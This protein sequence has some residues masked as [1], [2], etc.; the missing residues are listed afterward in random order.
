MNTDYEY[1]NEDRIDPDLICSI[2]F[3]P[4]KDPVT[5]PCGDAFCRT[6]ITRWI[7]KQDASCPLC[8]KSLSNR[9]LTPAIHMVRNILDRLQVTC[10]ACGQSNLLRGQFQMHVKNVCPMTM[11][12][13]PGTDVM[14]LW[15]GR[16]E[17][18][19]QHLLQS[20]IHSNTIEIDPFP[21]EDQKVTNIDRV[22]VNLRGIFPISS[23]HSFLGD[24]FGND[25]F[26][27]CLLGPRMLYW[28]RDSPM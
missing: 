7:E 10:L 25:G 28:P 13:C 18:L 1:L 27:L 2:C 8:R 21:T 23:L 5:G 22:D 16:R 17:Q 9:V 24:P 19:S 6:C 15:T 4:F 20:Q 11:I 3:S 14:C 12:S 26:L